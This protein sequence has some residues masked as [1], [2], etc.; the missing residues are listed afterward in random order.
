[1]GT[2]APPPLA[3]LLPPPLAARAAALALRTPGDLL[4]VPPYD[5]GEDLDAS[6][7]DVAALRSVA[8]AALLPPTL[9]TLADLAAAPRPPHLATGLPQLDAA[10]NG[11]LRGGLLCEAV[12]GAGVGK[13]Q[14]ALTLAARALAASPDAAVVWV[15]AEGAFSAG[16]LAALATAAGVG[17]ADAALDRVLV[18]PAPPGGAPALVASLDALAA[19]GDLSGRRVAL[20][21]VD[22]VPAA[23]APDPTGPAPSAADAAFAVADAARALKGVAEAC[24]C[25]VLGVN[26]V[27]SGGGGRGA[28]VAALGAAWAHAVSLRLALEAGGAPPSSPLRWA[29]LVKAPAA[30]DVAAPFVVGGAGVAPPPAAM[31]AAAAGEEPPAPPS[32]PAWADHEGGVLDAPLWADVGGVEAEGE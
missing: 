28:G 21:V 3:S 13:T 20:V 19:D 8:A 12:G 15:D 23:L 11:G 22:S 18:L 14:F 29:R 4:L 27:A 26:Q 31:M 32:R 24:A 17:D 1:M 7:A 6:P 10:L 2:A 5:L 30:G 9:P 25:V 16:R